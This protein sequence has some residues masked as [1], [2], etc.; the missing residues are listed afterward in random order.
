MCLSILV[1]INVSLMAISTKA[2]H[3]RDVY[4]HQ[5]CK[6]FVRLAK[7]NR[8]MFVCFVLRFVKESFVWKFYVIRRCDVKASKFLQFFTTKKTFFSIILTNKSVDQLDE[9]ITYEYQTNTVQDEN[10]NYYKWRPTQY[11]QEVCCEHLW[12]LI[13]SMFDF[14]IFLN[15][16]QRQKEG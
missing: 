2:I 9:Q 15:I 7:E 1:C 11:E 6:L 12:S 4:R 10:E 13:F 3:I 8:Q 14:M 5:K 16:Y